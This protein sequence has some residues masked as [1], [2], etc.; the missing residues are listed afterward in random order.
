MTD[1][2][3][4]LLGLG[5]SWWEGIIKLHEKVARHSPLW[6]TG[7]AP[8]SHIASMNKGSFKGSE[9]WSSGLYAGCL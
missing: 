8:L 4:V 5:M 7:L 6:Y 3:T 1:H 2:C 9:L